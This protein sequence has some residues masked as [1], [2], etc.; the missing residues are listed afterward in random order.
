M[1]TPL[2]GFGTP[3]A[4]VVRAARRLGIPVC[5][6]VRSW[7]NLTNKGLLREAP[8]Q[9]LVWNDLQQRGGGRAAR[10]AGGAGRRHRR[11]RVRPLVRLAAVAEPRAVLRGGRARPGA[12]D[13][14][15]RRVVAVH[16]PGRAGVR[17]AVGRA[18]AGARRPARRCRP[19]RPSAPARRR[20]VPRPRPRTTRRRRSGPAAAS[21]RSARTPAGTTTTPSSTAPPSSGSTRARR[22]RAAIVGRPVH[23]I[24]APEFR[25]TQAGTLHFQYLVD[26]DFGHVRRAD[27]L[28]EHAE[29]LERSLRE[30]DPEHLNE[31]FLLRFVRPFGLTTP[32]TPLAVDAVEELG[33]GGHRSPGNGPGARARRSL[34]AAP[35][36]RPGR[37]AAPA[38]QADPCSVAAGR[39]A[40]DRA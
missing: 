21:S 26:D 40:A 19:A 16:R 9:V 30:G 23:T 1:V 5:F 25:Q 29:Q 8:D 31:R 4:D 13:R 35:A 10:R 3:Q 17:P 27:T 22:S 32:A 34:R 6:P 20:R 37:A 36:G 24:L 11:A 28:P 33:A 2:I 39:P 7:D 14:A 38:G 15:L 18:A 12:A